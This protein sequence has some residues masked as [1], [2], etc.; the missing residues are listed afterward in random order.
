MGDCPVLKHLGERI[1][2]EIAVGLNGRVWIR[3]RSVSN[4]ILAVNA[5]LASEHMTGDESRTMI[6]KLF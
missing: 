2:Y 4:T 6:S 1:S 5:I 3:S